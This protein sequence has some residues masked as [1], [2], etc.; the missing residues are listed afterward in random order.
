MFLEWMPKLLSLPILK[1][2]NDILERYRGE[3]LLGIKYPKGYRLPRDFDRS[4][5]TDPIA[6]LIKLADFLSLNNILSG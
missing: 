6:S 1:Q 5:W 2:K 4:T 3:P